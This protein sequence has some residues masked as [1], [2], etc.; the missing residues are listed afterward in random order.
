MYIDI[1]VSCRK[2]EAYFECWFETS[3]E[4]L[5]QTSESALGHV[6]LAVV[7]VADCLRFHVAT[8]DLRMMI[9]CVYQYHGRRSVGAVLEGEASPMG[10]Y[11]RT[12]RATV[13]RCVGYL[14]RSQLN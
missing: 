4:R 14:F 12:L 7:A 2:Y 11:V 9:R 13:R 1:Q 10:Y 8:F 5:C 6:A 3:L